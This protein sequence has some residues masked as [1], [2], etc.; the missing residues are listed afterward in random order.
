MSGWDSN[1]TI[2][3]DLGGVYPCLPTAIDLG[4]APSYCTEGSLPHTGVDPVTS[5]VLT[6]TGVACII[7]GAA[8]VAWHSVTRSR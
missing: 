6:A 1:P 3:I 8:M 2:V 5:V 4:L 7:L